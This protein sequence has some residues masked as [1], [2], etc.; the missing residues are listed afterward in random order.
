MDDE[1]QRLRQEIEQLHAANRRAAREWADERTRLKAA[2]NGRDTSLAMRAVT[3]ERMGAVLRRIGV[4]PD[5]V[6][7][8]EVAA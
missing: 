1:T 7:R 2:L 6:A 5:A 4:D 8:G 3:I